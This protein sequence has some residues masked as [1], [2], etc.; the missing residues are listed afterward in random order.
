MLPTA[1]F[2]MS[3]AMDDQVYQPVALSPARDRSCPCSLPSADCLG[4]GW[5]GCP[6][7]VPPPPT[8]SIPLTESGGLSVA[9]A[10]HCAER[11]SSS[12]CMTQDWN[13]L[14]KLSEGVS[15]PNPEI[16]KFARKV[17]RMSRARTCVHG[18]APTQSATTASAGG[19]LN[20]SDW[21]GRRAFTCRSPRP[22]VS[23]TV[24]KRI[25]HW[26]G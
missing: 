17:G 19:R 7:A 18:K 25:E 22:Q 20:V 1:R 13:G 24:E 26:S 23:V 21:T 10:T 2:H 15:L 14:W 11:K 12:A 16:V 8:S 5:D 4:H 6:V 9:D 3:A